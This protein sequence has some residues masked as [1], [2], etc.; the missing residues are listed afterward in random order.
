[1]VTVFSKMNQLV[2]NLKSNNLIKTYSIIIIDKMPYPLTKDPRDNNTFSI[3]VG[4]IDIITGII[5]YLSQNY[6][7]SSNRIIMFLSFFYFCLGIW[8]LS[9]NFLRK[10]FL[11]WRGAVDIISAV[12]LLL[13]LSGSSSSTLS[14]FGI[15]IAI[16]G[17]I[18]L[19]LISTEQY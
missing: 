3:F 4:I 9:K 1:M 10:K 7:W 6:N 16:K 13:I 8:S 2:K 17:I 19:F 14:V 15:I 5:V 18:G 11:D 12:V